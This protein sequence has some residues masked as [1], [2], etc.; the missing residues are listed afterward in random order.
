MDGLVISLVVKHLSGRDLVMFAQVNI[1]TYNYC[2]TTNVLLKPCP[3]THTT[4]RFTPTLLE[5]AKLS[6]CLKV[7]NDVRTLSDSKISLSDYCTNITLHKSCGTKITLCIGRLIVINKLM[8]T[9][10]NFDVMCELKNNHV[11]PCTQVLNINACMDRLRH[12]LNSIITHTYTKVTI[13]TTNI[14]ID[15]EGVRNFVKVCMMNEHQR[16]RLH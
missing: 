11:Q 2:K 3:K 13:T 14:D 5:E 9:Y 15:L 16:K 12:K 8:Y 6:F 1:T 10:N 4:H 7:L